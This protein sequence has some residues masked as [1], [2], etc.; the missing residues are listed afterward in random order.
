MLLRVVGISVLLFGASLV[1][2]LVAAPRAGAEDRTQTATVADAN[3]PKE[4]QTSE[5]KVQ[6]APAIRVILPSPYQVRT[7]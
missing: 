2:S 6:P 1:G 7:N 4:T 5:Q 3:G